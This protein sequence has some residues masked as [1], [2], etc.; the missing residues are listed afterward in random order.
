MVERGRPLLRPPQMED[1]MAC[2]DHLEPHPECASGGLFR[3]T[4]SQ[5]VVMCAG[6]DVGA[7]G[8]PADQVSGRRESLEVLRLKRRLAVRS[9]EPSVRIPPRLPGEGLAPPRSSASALVIDSFTIP[10]L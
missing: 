1:L 6:R 8:V 2:L 5:E 9:R 4:A 3:F 10:D 7:L